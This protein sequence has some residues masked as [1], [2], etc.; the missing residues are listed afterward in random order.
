LLVLRASSGPVEYYCQ[1][2]DKYGQ[3]VWRSNFFAPSENDA[4]AAARTFLRDRIDSTCVFELWQGRRYICCENDAIVL[5]LGTIQAT[6]RPAP[7][8]R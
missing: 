2:L 4:I 8:A 3:A 5:E 1:L 6:G 7:D